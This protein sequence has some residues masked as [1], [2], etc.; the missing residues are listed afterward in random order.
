V[1]A[2]LAFEPGLILDKAAA[3]AGRSFP[4]TLSTLGPEADKQAIYALRY[5]SFHAAGW[6]GPCSTEAFEDRYDGLATSLSIAA[7]HAGACVGTIRLTFGGAGHGPETM[8]AQANFP[9]ELARVGADGHRRLVEFT[10]LAVEPD[11]ANTSFRTTLYGTL[12]RAATVV[13]LAGRVDY[14]VVAVHEKLSK[15]YRALC[16]F[17]VLARAAGYGDIAEPTHLLGREF[18]ALNARRSLRNAFFRITPHDVSAARQA[19][20]RVAPQVARANGVELEIRR[21]NSAS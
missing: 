15:V 7:H 1:I 14:A 8:P 11:L 3:A 12:V 16:G 19:L 13:A 21:D 6:I 20:R 5:R 10:R 18:A 2:E 9:A 4:I 17:E